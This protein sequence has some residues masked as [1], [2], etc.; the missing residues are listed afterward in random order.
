L[1]QLRLGFL[2]SHGGSNMQAIFDACKAGRLDANLCV[3]ISN[4]SRSTAL[5]RAKREQVPGYHLGGRTHPDPEELDDAILQ[6]LEKHDVNLVVLVGYMK[7]LGPKTVS[8]Y[9]GRILNIHPALLPKYGGKRFYGQAVHEAV[10]AAGESVTGVTIHLVDQM[11]DHGPIVAQT[12]VPVLDGDTADS[13]ADRVLSREHQFYSET[14]RRIQQGE[15]DL[16]R[17]SGGG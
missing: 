7:L 1:E 3:V 13:L 12:E 9:R 10:L 15:I 6:T 4:N 8:R 2:S 11:F 17:L 5:K 14:L 16:D